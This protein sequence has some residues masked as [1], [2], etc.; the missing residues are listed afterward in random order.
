MEKSISEIGA[1]DIQ[2][3][4]NDVNEL[5]RPTGYQ[6]AYISPTR[7]C[8]PLEKNAHFMEKPTLDKL[9]NNIAEDGF[10]SQLPFMM[11]RP[12]GKYLV[13]SGNHRVKAAIKAKLPYILTLFVENIPK[14]KQL[15]YQL[16]HNSLVGRDDLKMLKE[17]F[18]LIEGLDHKEFSGLNSMDFMDVEGINVSQINDGEI[19]LTEIKFL[20]VESRAQEVA[21]VLAELEKQKLDEHSAIVYGDF[22]EFIKTMTAIKAR[23]GIKSNT[24]AFGRMIEICGQYLT[25]NGTEERKE[26]QDAA[27]QKR[28]GTASM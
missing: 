1:A 13:L 28:I 8:V 18:E 27:D 6:L 23:F 25:S 7:D 20:F 12:D 15:A 17:L 9:V 16:S 22:E 19:E 24:V 14:D 2:A 21:Q 4:L 26:C 5:L 11:K 10:L 3:R